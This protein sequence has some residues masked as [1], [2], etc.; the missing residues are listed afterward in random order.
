M[1]SYEGARAISSDLRILLVLLLGLR[2]SL[3]SSLLPFVLLPSLILMGLPGYHLHA[4]TTRCRH[5]WP[6]T[7][8]F[9]SIN[10]IT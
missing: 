10:Q 8:S 3:L 4:A 9:R 2:F 7:G 5:L 6:L 1:F